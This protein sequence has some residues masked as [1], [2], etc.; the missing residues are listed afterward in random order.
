MNNYISVIA[1]YSTV[2]TFGKFTK[3]KFIGNKLIILLV[4]ISAVVG[5]FAPSKIIIVAVCGECRLFLVTI[6]VATYMRSG[7]ASLI[8][9]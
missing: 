7:I 5:I 9:F 1:K 2:S 8:L 3:S 4:S 6:A